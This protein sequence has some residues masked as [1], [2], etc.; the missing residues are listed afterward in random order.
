M[1][2]TNDY[3]ESEKGEKKDMSTRARKI[4]NAKTKT[5]CGVRY[6]GSMWQDNQAV[7]I[8]QTRIRYDLNQGRAANGSAFFI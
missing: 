1:T 6:R 7:R 3:V 4:L 8:R 5:P 2:L